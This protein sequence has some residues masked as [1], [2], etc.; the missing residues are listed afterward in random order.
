M[1]ENSANVNMQHVHIAFGVMKSHAVVIQLRPTVE[2]VD[3]GHLQPV[4]S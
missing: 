3:T 4:G 1:S 2:F